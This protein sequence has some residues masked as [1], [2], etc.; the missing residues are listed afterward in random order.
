[1]DQHLSEKAIEE[2]PDLKATDGNKATGISG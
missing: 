1:V 2:D